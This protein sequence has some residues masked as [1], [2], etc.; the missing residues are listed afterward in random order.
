[1]ARE[2]GVD[3]VVECLL[4][5]LWHLETLRKVLR[6]RRTFLSLPL[7]HSVGVL[8]DVIGLLVAE[9]VRSDGSPP[10]YVM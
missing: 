7:R 3:E 2:E 4:A 9:L 1:V 5:I 8:S 10:G 6:R